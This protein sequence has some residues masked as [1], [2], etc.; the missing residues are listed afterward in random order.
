MHSGHARSPIPAA[1]HAHD[2]HLHGMDAAPPPIETKLPSQLA[3]VPWSAHV[4]VV[5]FVFKHRL[6]HSPAA[7]VVDGP[8]VVVAAGVV[9]GLVT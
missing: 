9:A 5:R 2:N 3:S 6:A 4:V 1:T 7:P 8:A